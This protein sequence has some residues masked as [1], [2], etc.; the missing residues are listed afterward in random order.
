MSHRCPKCGGDLASAPLRC[1]NCD[2]RLITL[3]EWRTLSPFY[4][5]YALYMQG[6]WPTS[7]LAGQKN[8]YPSGTPDHQEFCHGE[9][10]RMLDVQDGEE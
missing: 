2:W 10:R 5:G 1:K 3:A 7:E 4:K 6:A 8:P 9:R